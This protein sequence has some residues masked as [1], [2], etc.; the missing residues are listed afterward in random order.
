MKRTILL[1]AFMGS[2]VLLALGVLAGFGL[3]GGHLPAVNL[4]VARRLPRQQPGHQR[5]RLAQANAE[6]PGDQD[7]KYEYIDYSRGKDELYDMTRDPY[8]AH[9]I[10][11]DPPEGVL[12][13]MRANLADLRNCAAEECTTAEGP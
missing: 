13:E 5:H 9:S 10:H 2:A 12:A 4:G 6:Q 8:R 3:T 1:A 11:A 7:P